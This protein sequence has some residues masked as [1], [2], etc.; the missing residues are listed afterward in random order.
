MTLIN[1]N[2]TL[3]KYADDSAYR[4]QIE[5]LDQSI[6][7][8]NHSIPYLINDALKIEGASLNQENITLNMS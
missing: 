3:L 7:Y 6:V 4:F 5:Y 1:S 2:M 8:T